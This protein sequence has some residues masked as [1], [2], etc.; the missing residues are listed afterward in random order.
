M[1]PQM[2]IL[3][4]STLSFWVEHEFRQSAYQ[5]ILEERMGRPLSKRLSNTSVRSWLL[6]FCNKNEVCTISVANPVATA[7]MPPNAGLQTQSDVENSK[8]QLGVVIGWKVCF[9]FSLL[10]ELWQR[11]FWNIFEIS[12]TT[13]EG[14]LFWEVSVKTSPGKCIFNSIHGNHLGTAGMKSTLRS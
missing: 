6:H 14:M 7:S 3:W 2:L 9:V 1:C 13:Q 4:E 10:G 8:N 12:Q 5:C 11:Y